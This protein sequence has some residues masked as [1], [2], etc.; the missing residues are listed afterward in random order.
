MVSA[1]DGKIQETINKVAV[2]LKEKIKA[3]E[4]TTFIK[5]GPAK[6]RLP[7]DQD[8]YYKRA[9]AILRTVYIRGPIGVNKLRVKF[10]SSK[11]R[12]YKPAKFY[13]AGGKIIRSI[14]Q[15]LEKSE[16][17]IQKTI[18]THKGRVVTNKGRS[19]FDKN[20]VR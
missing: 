12:G 18:K 6:E 7:D 13:K 2:A 1:Y 5:T 17:V 20:T 10:G 19:F 4:W 8:W 15:Q 16:L 3:P 9:A 11:N 14:L